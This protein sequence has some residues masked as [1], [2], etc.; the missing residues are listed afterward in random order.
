[1]LR[2]GAPLQVNLIQIIVWNVWL[3]ELATAWR[4]VAEVG[5]GT[6]DT[7]DPYYHHSPCLTEHFQLSS[8]K[9]NT[10]KCFFV[11]NKALTINVNSWEHMV[12]H[13]AGWPSVTACHTINSQCAAPSIARV[14]VVMVTTGSCD[15]ADHASLKGDRSR[16]FSGSGS[17]FCLW[18]PQKDCISSRSLLNHRASVLVYLY[19]NYI[20]RNLAS[21]ISQI[22]CCFSIYISRSPSLSH[23]GSSLLSSQF[24]I[25][26]C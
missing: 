4:L 3:Q 10:K 1:M 17:L 21:T 2:T 12:P 19:L 23:S 18:G 26:S 13:V 9:K 16:A 15:Q 14:C 20:C 22:Q 25:M 8:V 5:L 7:S 6:H 11:G 24:R